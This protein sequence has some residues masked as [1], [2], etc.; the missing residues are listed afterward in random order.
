MN[1][2]KEVDSFVAFGKLGGVDHLLVGLELEGIFRFDGCVG[3]DEAL[4]KDEG[5]VISHP[6]AALHRVF[7]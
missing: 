1:H 5:C 3:L 4:L 2:D 7:I 6:R